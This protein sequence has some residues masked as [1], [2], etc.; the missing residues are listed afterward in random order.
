MGNAFFIVVEHRNHMAAMTPAAIP[1]SQLT[2][3]YDFRAANSYTGNTGAGQK[4]IKSGVW[5][6]FAG[7]G[8]QI[9][10]VGGY[11]INSLDRIFWGQKN[12]T[13]SDYLNQDFD[14]NGDVNGLDRIFWSYNNGVFSNLPK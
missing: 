10:D 11:D 5:A 1:V 3:S 4:E 6:L 7:D 8:E 12:G 2:I 14:L 9:L 13:F